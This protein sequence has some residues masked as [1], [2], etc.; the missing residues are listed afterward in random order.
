MDLK[1]RTAIVKLVMKMRMKSNSFSKKITPS[2]N[3]TGFTLIEVL[4]VIVIISIIAGVATLSIH[5]NQNKQVETLAHEL[6]N[7]IT[8]AEEEAMLR[9]A[10]LGLALTPQYY[11][12]YEY[13]EKNHSWQPLKNHVFRAR[14]IPNKIKITLTIN[15]ADIPSDGK[16]KLII[17]NS[18]DI[19]AFIISIGFIDQKPLYKIIGKPN[20]RV[21]TAYVK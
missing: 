7:L 8:L 16:P 6:T 9:P 21:Y 13:Q 15:D 5:F 3:L 11:Q 14:N 19:P 2:K 18:G 1:A 20:G 17:S 10:V 12:F 4:I